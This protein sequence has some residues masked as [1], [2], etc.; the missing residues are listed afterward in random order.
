MRRKRITIT[1]KQNTINKVDRLIDHQ[2]IRN[3]SHAIEY[4]LEQY[5]KSSVRKAVI[6][7][8][9]KG[10]KMRPFTYE[11]PKSLLPVGGKP[12][13]EHLITE[14]KRN[15]ITEIILCV[16][17]L[18][19]KIKEY[20]GSG[21][22]FGVHI[23]YSAEKEPLLTGGAILKVKKLIDDEPFLVIN[24]DVITTL[25]IQDLIDFHES[26]QTVVTVALTTVNEPKQF[27][28]LAL[29]GAKLVNFYQRPLGRSVKSH[30]VNC[31]LYVCE[32]GVFQHFPKNQISFMFE[33][34][35]N[36]LIQKREASGFVFEGS[37]FDV[38]NL[39]GYEAAIKQFKHE[40][41]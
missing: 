29:H 40:K 25:N 11:M 41:K 38:G 2:K 4:V 23:T 35:L 8:G 33:D 22:K 15:H 31:G 26:E 3:R 39:S 5:T 30:L 1:L 32:P 17:Y 16:G 21:E 27:G 12:V 13:L 24:G 14:L 18:G 37:W 28:Q 34:V 6:L 10:T 19:D 36:T 20:F 9:G 7:A